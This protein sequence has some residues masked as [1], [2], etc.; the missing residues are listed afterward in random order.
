MQFNP[1]KIIVHFSVVSSS[2]LNIVMETVFV[3]PSVRTFLQV[4]FLFFLFIPIKLFSS[5]LTIMAL[6]RMADMI[7]PSNFW[8]HGSHFQK[9]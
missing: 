4:S 8:R 2:V 1:L 5:V 6:N 9:T 7:S 3:L